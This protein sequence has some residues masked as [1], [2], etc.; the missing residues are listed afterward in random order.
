MRGAI[1]TPDLIA[2]LAIATACDLCGEVGPLHVDH[3]HKTGAV[4]GV[5]C[6]LCNTGLGSFRDSPTLLA[7]AINYLAGLDAT[8]AS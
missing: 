7:R 2:R 8:Q 4:R 5:L 6:H 3:C 1:V